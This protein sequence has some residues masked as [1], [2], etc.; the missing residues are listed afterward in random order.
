ML[1]RAQRLL[2]DLD[3]QG[4]RIL[5]PTPIMWEYLLGI[6]SANRDAALSTFNKRFRVIPFDAL[7]ASIASELWQNNKNNGKA[8]DG[9]AWRAG[10]GRT[11]MKV[12]CQLVAVALANGADAIY[13]HDD[14]IRKYAGKRIPV[15]PLPELPPVLFEEL[16]IPS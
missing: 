2:C 4:A 12:D 8:L 16:A 15:L 10:H 3:K 7:A 14:D 13:S 6:S 5:I 11:K 9:A 1:P